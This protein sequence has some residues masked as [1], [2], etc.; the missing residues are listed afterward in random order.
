MSGRLALARPPIAYSIVT[1]RS[2]LVLDAIGPAARAYRLGSP[3]RR[4][5]SHYAAP[6]IALSSLA[7]LRAACP[8]PK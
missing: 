2:L 8:Y 6:R 3:N 5:Y 1:P 4:R 7:L